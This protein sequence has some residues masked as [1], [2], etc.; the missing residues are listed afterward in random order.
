MES[1]LLG[2]NISATVPIKIKERMDMEINMK[3]AKLHA[4][5][6]E[7]PIGVIVV[8]AI[9]CFMVGAGIGASL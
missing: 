4:R 6:K 3:L 8:I 7:R 2:D 1:N 9:Y 5:I